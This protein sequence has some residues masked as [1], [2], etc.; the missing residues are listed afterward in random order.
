[1]MGGGKPVR[2][3]V[4]AGMPD[5][6]EVELRA[7][8]REPTVGSAEVMQGNSPS[9]AHSMASTKTPFLVYLG[10]LM[11]GSLWR[12][13]GNNPRKAAA[14]RRYFRYARSDSVGDS[15]ITFQNLFGKHQIVPLAGDN[16]QHLCIIVGIERIEVHAVVQTE[17]EMYRRGRKMGSS[18][19]LRVGV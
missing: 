11:E 3:I 1:M 12:E 19:V 18:V 15:I 14:E 2:S 9:V 13:G 8:V 6:T 5:L 4:N 7:V 10:L 17:H 16:I